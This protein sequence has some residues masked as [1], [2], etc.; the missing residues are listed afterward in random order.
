MHDGDGFVVI[1]AAATEIPSHN[2]QGAI[3]GWTT[4]NGNTSIVGNVLIAGWPPSWKLSPVLP[5]RPSER[6]RQ[7]STTLLHPAG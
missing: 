3:D 7:S 4:D 2:E 6:W 5:R 1:I